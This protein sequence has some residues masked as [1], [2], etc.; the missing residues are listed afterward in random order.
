MPKPIT[1]DRM[2]LERIL[3]VLDQ[4]TKDHHARI[5]RCWICDLKNEIWIHLNNRLHDDVGQPAQEGEATEP[6][7]QAKEVEKQVLGDVTNI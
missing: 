3:H 6:A 5:L 1:T 2:M 7:E 4:H